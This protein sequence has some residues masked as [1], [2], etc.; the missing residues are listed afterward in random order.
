MQAPFV[1]GAAFSQNLPGY[2][3]A[4][5]CI[6]DAVRHECWRMTNCTHFRFD[7]PVP[8]GG[9]AALGR[10]GTHQLSGV[11]GFETLKAQL[12]Y[13]SGSGRSR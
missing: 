3:K 13:L 12:G 8:G 1:H 2:C 7:V 9:T 6:A 10:F 11:S 5:F 4:K